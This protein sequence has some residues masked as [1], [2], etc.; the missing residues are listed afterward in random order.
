MASS[1]RMPATMTVPTTR[2]SVTIAGCQVSRRSRTSSNMKPSQA[3]LR[4]L[5]Q[6]W[7]RMLASP[8]LTTLADH[9]KVTSDAAARLLWRRP[10]VGFSS[11]HVAVAANRKALSKYARLPIRTKVPISAPHPAT[12]ARAPSAAGSICRGRACNSWRNI[13]HIRAC[14]GNRR[15]SRRR[16]N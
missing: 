10:P 9:S 8:W 13:D 3:R 11:A 14:D 5:S 12:T 6:T 16:D 1:S 4:K 2:Y 15:G 7:E